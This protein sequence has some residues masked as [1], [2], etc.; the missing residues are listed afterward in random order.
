MT[1]AILGFL[2]SFLEMLA[3]ALILNPMGYFVSMIVTTTSSFGPIGLKTHLSKIVDPSE[4]GKV[5][6]LMAVIDGFAPIIAASVFTFVFQMTIDQIPGL[7]F[8]ILA[9]FSVIP[10]AIAM[11]IDLT[12]MK[13]IEC[14]NKTIKKF[15]QY[16]S[17]ENGYIRLAEEYMGSSYGKKFQQ[18]KTK[19]LGSDSNGVLDS[20]IETV[21][22][23]SMTTTVD[24]ASCRS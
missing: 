5:F 11:F 3:L 2:G 24:T 21:D 6:T 17:I 22:T 12:D 4:L 23:Q 14:N 8:L 9:V 18:I 20:G 13:R 16:D 10:L 19:N 15:N 1:L 7:C